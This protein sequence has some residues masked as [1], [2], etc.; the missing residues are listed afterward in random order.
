LLFPKKP[1]SKRPPKTSGKTKY[2][3]Q[4]VLF[5]GMPAVNII[6]TLLCI[7]GNDIYSSES[8]EIENREDVIRHAQPLSARPS[9]LSIEK[10][11]TLDR[12]VSKSARIE[13]EFML[14]IDSG[15]FSQEAQFDLYT[16]HFCMH[17]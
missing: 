2:A 6:L 12:R 10:D 14:H 17:W 7:A 16:C 5:F 15:L 9:I 11:T 1:T 8:P 3:E 4:V 13:N